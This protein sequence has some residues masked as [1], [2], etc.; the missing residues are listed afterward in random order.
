[1]PDKVSATITY[2]DANNRKG[3]KAITDINPNADNSAVSALCTG[4]NALTTN[5]LTNIE[6]VERTNI[7]NGNKPKLTVAII[8]NPSFLKLTGFNNEFMMVRLSTQAVPN[9]T[10]KFTSPVCVK[11]EGDTNA[12]VADLSFGPVRKNGELL[13]G[14]GITGYIHDWKSGDTVTVEFYFDE[15]E[16]TARTTY[17]LTIRYED[18]PI[19]EQL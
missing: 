13:E 4:L 14:I 10:Y 9:Y 16:E 12:R 3:M 2:L 17:R 7:T 18:T 19:W 5:T 15:T 8:D 6:K 11:N 1:M